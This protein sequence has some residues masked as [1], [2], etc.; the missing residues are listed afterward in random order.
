MAK[1]T[2][3]AGYNLA[4]V[5]KAIYTTMASHGWSMPQAKAAVDKGEVEVPDKK[6]ADELVTR[7]MD[8]GAEDIK[9][10]FS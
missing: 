4:A 8:A 6:T 1:V 10:P 3:K 2:F 5:A 9:N 7:L